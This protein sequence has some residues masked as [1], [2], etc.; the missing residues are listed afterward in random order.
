[1]AKVPFTKLQACID[2]CETKTFYYDRQTNEVYYSVKHYL[3]VK[4]KLEMIE[5]II[6]QS[7]DENGYY[8]PLRLRIFT[9]LEMV[10][11][12]TNLSFTEKMKEDPLK[13]Y[14]I[15]ESTGI[16]KDVKNV[17]SEN[18][19]DIIQGTIKETIESIY[20]YKNSLMGILDAVSNDYSNLNL[21]AEAIREKIGDPK[22][23]ELLKAIMTKLG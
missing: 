6:N 2:G 13:L 18:D 8:N 23:L 5:K 10:Y 15:L 21:D 19:W 1:M 4:E 14:D 3:P 11:A 12:Y 7:I 16:F 22:H 20:A 9:V 17:I